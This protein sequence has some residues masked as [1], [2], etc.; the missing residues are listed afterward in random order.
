MEVVEDMI[1]SRILASTVALL[2]SVGLACAQQPDVTPTPTLPLPL[3]LAAVAGPPTVVPVPDSGPLGNRLWGD[4]EYLLWWVKGAHL[5]PLLITGN[6]SAA[7]APTSSVPVPG[8]LALVTTATSGNVSAPL[9]LSQTI[10][11]NGFEQDRR[12]GGRFTLGYWLDADQTFGV[13]G[14]YFVLPWHSTHLTGASNGSPTLAI[15]FVNAATGQETSYTIAQPSGTVIS[16]TDLFIGGFPV[17]HVADTTTT[18]GISG[19]VAIVSS[20]QLQGAEANG[21]WSALRGPEYS[22]DLLAGFRYVQLDDSLSLASTVIQ[23]QTQTTVSLGIPGVPASTLLNNFTSQVNRADRFEAHNNFYGGQVG[24]RG[25]YRFGSLFF[26]AAGKV[27]LGTMTERVDISGA[28]VSSTTTTITPQTFP[29]AGFPIGTA[30][31]PPVTTQTNQHSFGGLFA[32]PS[33]SGGTRNTFAVVPE[34]NLKV[35]FD[36]TERLRG[37]VGYSFLYMSEVVR[38]DEQI[39][40][41]INPGLLASP[42]VVGTPLRPTFQFQKTDYW[43]QGLDFGLEFRF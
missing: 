29:L 8:G 17:V 12:D 31:G 42:P 24:A 26:R 21:I 35:G 37:T 34:A 22:L 9:S 19:G 28:T 30:A 40:R 13:E 20:S 14:S 43:A 5:P 25:E 27:A 16:T 33:N 39:D 23:T 11:G 2:A 4:G 36:F 7:F 6:P 10:V 38:A 1:T 41:A 18:T 3:P 15:P 32:Q